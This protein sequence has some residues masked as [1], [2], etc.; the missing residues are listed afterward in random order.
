MAVL[1]HAV[2]VVLFH[3]AL[4]ETATATGGIQERAQT[5]QRVRGEMFYLLA[6]LQP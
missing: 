2:T 6:A 5:I 4:Q 1:A 3:V